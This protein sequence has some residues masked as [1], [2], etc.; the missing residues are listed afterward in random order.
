MIIILFPHRLC[1]ATPAT[2]HA[3]TNI[4]EQKR[5]VQRVCRSAYLSSSPLRSVSPSVDE[6]R[7]GRI[8]LWCKSFKRDS[9]LQY[10][11]NF[12]VS[13]TTPFVSVVLT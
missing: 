11:E 7:A 9:V 2:V 8:L 13:L 4:I 6:T 10:S 3:A 1:F 5:A 12:S